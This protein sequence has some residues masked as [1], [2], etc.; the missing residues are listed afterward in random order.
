MAEHAGRFPP[1]SSPRMPASHLSHLE[2]LVKMLRGIGDEL[3]HILLNLLEGKGRTN[4]GEPVATPLALGRDG[5]R[6]TLT[7]AFSIDRSP[8]LN[9]F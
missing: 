5:I 1:G 7:T 9:G 2:L 8:V 4:L 6:L 3:V